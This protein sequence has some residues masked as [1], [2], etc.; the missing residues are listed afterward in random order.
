MAS[1]KRGGGGT[2]RRGTRSA[3]AV[4]KQRQRDHLQVVSHL[5]ERSPQLVQAPPAA[6]RG[7]SGWGGVG[8]VAWSTAVEVGPHGNHCPTFG[9]ATA[10]MQRK[11]R[12]RRP[13][14]CQ[15]P[16]TPPPLLPQC[17]L[18]HPAGLWWP[19]SSPS[20][21][22]VRARPPATLRPPRPSSTASVGGRAGLGQP[23]SFSFSLSHTQR[24]ALLSGAC[25]RS[26]LAPAPRRS[27]SIGW[28][29]SQGP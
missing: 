20:R 13:Q 7:R 19:S 9:H 23:P 3:G 11:V 21:K 16:E 6:H 8:S 24:H 29:G 15:A 28:P 17:S 5:P 1:R 26:G 27:Q 4:P 22:G 25:L 14:P 2:T 12:Q 10:R 18:A